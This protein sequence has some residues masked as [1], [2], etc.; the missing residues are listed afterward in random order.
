MEEEFR[1][2]ADGQRRVSRRSRSRLWRTVPN[3]YQKAKEPKELLIIPGASHI[4]LYYKPEYVPQAVE[5][6]TQF[7]NAHL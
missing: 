3:A 4:D 7:F 5:K 2:D 1:M 6:L